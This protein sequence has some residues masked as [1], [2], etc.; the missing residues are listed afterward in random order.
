MVLNSSFS[1][2]PYTY[3]CRPPPASLQTLGETC[4][5]PLTLAPGNGPRSDIEPSER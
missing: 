4:R 2:A 1:Y 5:R 3:R